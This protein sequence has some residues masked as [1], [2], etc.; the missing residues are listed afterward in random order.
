MH[1]HLSA[2]S[3]LHAVASKA[4]AAS[5]VAEG[6]RLYRWMHTSRRIDELEQELIAR[7]EAFF[8]VGAAGHEASACLAP[9]LIRDDYLHCHYR[10]KA[11]MLARG[12]PVR[13]FFDSL[14]CNATSHSAGRQMSAHLSAPALNLLSVVGPVGNSALQAAGI[15]QQIKDHASQP[16]VLC[17]MGDGSTQQGEVLEAIAEAVRST[18]PVLFLVHDNR[19]SISTRTV[20]QTF[21]SLPAGDT[22]TFYGLPIHRIDGSD[23][24]RCQR[25]FA[26]I[27]EQIRRT[28]GPAICVLAV[29]R[30]TDHTNAD[31]ESV[32]RSAAEISQVR[33]LNDPVEKAREWLLSHGALHRDL[34]R[35]HAAIDAE[36]RA[37]AQASLDVA[38]PKAVRSAM[39]GSRQVC[40]EFRGDVD[41]PAL[42]MA[43]A[44][45]DTLR[46]RMVQDPR[47]SLF[48]QDIEDPKGDVFGVTRGLS[49]AFP[50]RV[51]NAPLSESTIV[52]TSIGRALAGGRPVAFLQ[53]ADFLPLAFNQ[54]ATELASMAWRTQ[55][56]WRAPVILMVSCGAYRP[57]LGPFHAHTFD[58]L[59]AHLPGIDVAVPSTAADA[60]GMLNVAFDNEQPTVILYPKAQLHARAHLSSAN[61]KALQVPVGT[62]RVVRSG[63]DLTMVAWGNTVALCAK[64]ADALAQAGAS[65]EVIDLRWLAPWDRDAVLRSVTKTRKLLVVHEDNVSAGFGAE[66]MAST[67]ETIGADVVYRRVARA[68]TFVPCNFGNQLDVLPS[69]RRTLEMAASMLGLD[70]RW[71]PA[72]AAL[73]GWQVVHAIG[74]SPADQTV[75]VVEL[76]VVVGQ[77]VVAGQTIAGLEADKAVVDLAAPA[78]GIVEHLHVCVGD[79]LAVDTPLMTLRVAHARQLQP[80]AEPSDLPHL[81]RSRLPSP[82]ARLQVL[83]GSPSTTSTHATHTVLLQG[84]GTARGSTRLHNCELAAMLPTWAAADGSGDG[85]GI[86]ERTGIE[87]RTVAGVEQDAVSMAL[88]AARKALADAGLAANELSL[89]I[90]STSTPLAIS[91][92][93]ACQVLHRLAPG[94]RMPAY[95]LQAA[96]S[97]YL[98]ALAQ[99]WD[100]LQ[101]HP[102]DRVLVLTSEVMRS[103]VDIRDPQ[104]S[105]I[106]ADAATATVLCT[107]SH[108]PRPGNLQAT[109]FMRPVLSARGDGGSTLGVPLPGQGKYVYMDGKRVFTEAIR[110]MSSALTEACVVGGL[111]L[112][113]LD[114]IVP[115]Q[116]NGRII[117]A[118]RS[119]LKLDA[120]KVWNEIRHQGNT[121]SS[122][123]PLALDT[124]LRHRPTPLHIGICAF[125]AGYTS[126]AAILRSVE[127]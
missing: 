31:D 54:I 119:R 10:D 14:V 112:D 28:R 45:R 109:K 110:D 82:Q 85:D 11:L 70:L 120:H 78:D 68:D 60:A 97:G 99:A 65:A 92:S 101:Q 106:F 29:E 90:C 81:T 103:I 91:P 2:V 43:E 108:A 50:G 95:D 100:F 67:V 56:G 47:V 125:G 49:T 25:G 87:S 83:A 118:L 38:S 13:E 4:P 102:K 26:R 36:V 111:T 17:S 41:L 9:L 115:H 32:Y 58:T 42:T 127:R 107:D 72:S 122:S 7:G 62:A 12:V 123:I 104:T 116:A 19:Y 89:I 46:A 77:S 15:A 18:L 114:L 64:A 57:G 63:A 94:C 126:G 124:V 16:L 22:D 76:P 80:T 5:A 74:S 33:M 59:L 113:A 86:F 48:G 51:R 24:D 84:L 105:P 73:A 40:T 44:L 79:R 69:F 30:L 39:V 88:D 121:S 6:L 98:Y 66:V 8:H 96:C 23:F 21:F 1:K 35:L 55:G 71:Q 20:G 27:V 61:V 52:G 93:T 37:A 75:V 117:D 3:P 34:D 53:F